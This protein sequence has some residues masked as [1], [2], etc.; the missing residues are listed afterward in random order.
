MNSH[1]ENLNKVPFFA[2]TFVLSPKS[3]LLFWWKNI[4]CMIKMISKT[5][6]LRWWTVTVHQTRVFQVRTIISFFRYYSLA[7]HIWKPATALA[8]NAWLSWFV[9]YWDCL[10]STHIICIYTCMISEHCYHAHVNTLR[11]SRVFKNF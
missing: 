9:F 4:L 11:A 3:Y 7:S 8:K 5:P 1:R 10:I 2:D 6:R